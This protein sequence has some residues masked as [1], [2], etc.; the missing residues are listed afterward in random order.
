[1]HNPWLHR[2]AVLLAVCTLFLV[3]AGALVTSHEAGLSVP[4]WPLSYG[5]VMPEM[6]GGVFYE[7]GHRLV[8]TTVG[9]LTIILA[10]WLWR[11]DGRRWM[12]RLG[13]AAVGA[14]IL[15]G[16]L[17]GL[18]VLFLLPP[19]ISVSH[20]SLAQLF[21]STTVAVALF[22]SESWRRGPVV[23]TDT[24]SPSLRMLS[25]LC[26]VAILGQ[27]ALGAAYRHQALGIIPHVAGALVVSGLVLLTGIFALLQFGSHRALRQSAVA[28]L[29][30]T[31]LQVFL[32]VAAYMSRVA[33]ADAA[34]PMPV[35]VAFTAVH[36]AVGALTMAASVVLAIQAF[37][38]LSPAVE[39]STSSA[40]A[41][42]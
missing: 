12:R 10:L 19:A 6:K 24:G 8:A 2:F 26:A 34:Q 5:R 35:M 20:A 42:S 7:H 29:F 22:T 33:T 21:F 11:A 36:V 13:F 28:L 16:V 14:V 30:V 9:F 15:Q 31:M 25:I 23:V 40:T 18:T 39:I 32:G 37:R 1:M 41:T 17:G 38:N 4:D 27:L 3:V